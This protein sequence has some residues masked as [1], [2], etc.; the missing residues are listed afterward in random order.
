MERFNMTAY[1]L[2]PEEDRKREEAVRPGPPFVLAADNL[3]KRVL[4]IELDQARLQKVGMAFHYLTGVSWAPV[5][6]LLR[7][8]R[9][10]NPVAAGLA[11]GASMSLVLDATLTPAIGASAPTPSTPHRPT[12]APSSRTSSTAWP[13][14]ASSRPAGSCSAAGLPAGDA[15]A[16]RRRAVK[17]ELAP[18]A[19]PQIRMNV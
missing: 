8:T 1:R 15:F 9:R 3:L 17:R 10:W 12:S 4:G 11:T 6:M 14:P 7:R 18:P 19:E 13:S 16:S 2:E 5:Y